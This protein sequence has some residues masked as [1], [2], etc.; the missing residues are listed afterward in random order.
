MQINPTRWF[1]SS[2]N[3]CV[4]VEHVILRTQREFLLLFLFLVAEMSVVQFVIWKCDS[5]VF[6]FNLP[7][8]QTYVNF[9]GHLKH[10]SLSK[11]AHLSLHVNTAVNLSVR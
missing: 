3:W 10:V 8:T 2:V 4:C 1:C 6:I 7:F 11:H 5:Q 9:S